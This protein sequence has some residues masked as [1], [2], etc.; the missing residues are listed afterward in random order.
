MVKAARVERATRVEEGAR[1]GAAREAA[2]PAGS[3][4]A[5]EESAGWAGG[6]AG[7]MEALFADY[8]ELV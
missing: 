7:G 8:P 2:W 5:E 6:R 1:A 3:M 4:G